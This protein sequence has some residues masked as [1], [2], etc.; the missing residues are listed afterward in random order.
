M[1]TMELKY[2]AKCDQTGEIWETDNFKSLVR[3]VRY[4]FRV[5]AHD[6]KYFE[7]RS[8]TLRLS[9]VYHIN[10]HCYYHT[11]RNIANIMVSGILGVVRYYIERS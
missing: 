10:G 2:T 3:I 6:F 5:T 9:I 11:V 4:A 8:A 7:C 1:E